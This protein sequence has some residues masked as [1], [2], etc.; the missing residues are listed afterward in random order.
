MVTIKVN[1]RTKAGQALIATAKVMAQKYAG[2]DI[3]EDDQVLLEKMKL[4][5]QS[6]LLSE[7]EQSAFVKELEKMAN[8]I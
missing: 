3:M 6:D 4:N 8:G 1:E 5:H 7:Q 2:I